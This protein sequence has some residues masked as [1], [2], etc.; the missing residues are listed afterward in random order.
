MLPLIGIFSVGWSGTKFTIT[1]DIYWPQYL[2][3]MMIIVE[4]WVE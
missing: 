3:Q 2:P 4:Q 1:E